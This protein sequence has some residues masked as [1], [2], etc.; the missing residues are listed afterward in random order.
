MY[1]AVQSFQILQRL[2][3]TLSGKATPRFIPPG[4]EILL[5]TLSYGNA[6]ITKYNGLPDI[7]TRPSV[8][9]K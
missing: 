2:Y 1:E 4:D 3:Q 9:F 7:Q 5:C 6:R 8:D